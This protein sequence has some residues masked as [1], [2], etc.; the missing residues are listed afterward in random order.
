MLRDRVTRFPVVAS[1]GDPIGTLK[2]CST[3]RDDVMGC[4]KR[5]WKVQISIAPGSQASD[6]AG[7]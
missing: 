3:V 7:A 6:I 2:F 4:P 5:F 1:N